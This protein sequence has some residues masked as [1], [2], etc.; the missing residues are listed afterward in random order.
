MK[1]VICNPCS[2]ISG[3]AYIPGDKSISHRALM[4]ASIA[5]GKSHIKNLLIG[6]DCIATLQVMRSL[7]VHIELDQN[8][9]TIDGKGRHSLLETSSVL[10]CKNSGTTMRLMAGLLAPMPFM[11][12]LDG[13]E[14]LKNRPM[15]RII[16]PLTTMNA[17]IF[18]RKHNSLA[19]LAIL[20]TKNIC[21]IT[22]KLIS[23]S[24]Q[25]KS[26]II[27]AAL[28]ATDT[29]VILNTK[30]T[31]DHTEK[32]LQHMGASVESHQD[33]VIVKPISSS[34]K[35]IDITIPGDM[36]SAA[37]ILVAA[38]LLAKDG[39]VLRSVGINDTRTG[40]VDALKKMGA[41]ISY[42]NMSN[43]FNE[44]VADI[45]VK[46]SSLRGA[47]FAGNHIVRMID[48]IPIL[49]LLATQ[50]QGQTIIKDAQELKVK[51]SDRINKVV[52]SLR[53]LGAD[54]KET[55]DGMIINGPTKLNGGELFSFHDHRLA[56][57]FSI[58][59]LISKTPVKVMG[60][61]VTSDSFPGFYQLLSDLGADICEQTND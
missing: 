56:M 10:D 18:G 24:A 17:K 49:A 55:A 34:L 4:F 58:A 45:Y 15:S 31:R 1:T 30:D 53:K 38:A 20:A 60:A 19:P 57:M 23:K 40:I 25:V 6:H 21:G 27:L 22:H 36:S 39:V 28:Y 8:S 42:Q 41:D 35:P 11:S 50:A 33:K 46:K 13:T 12:I 51:E 44:P 37:F 29:S 47:L 61:E 43:D 3:Q 32:L 5:Q 2:H 52:I 59:G 16:D 26:A 7:G 14:Q 54:I 9:C 48:E